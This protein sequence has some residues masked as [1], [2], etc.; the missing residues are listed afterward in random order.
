[1]APE[2]H[3]TLRHHH[4]G[5]I[6]LNEFMFK[7][8]IRIPFKFGIADLLQALF[9]SKLLQGYV[10]FAGKGN[11]KLIDNLLDSVPEWKLK[12]FCDWLVSPI[13]GG[14]ATRTFL[15]AGG[16]TGGPPAVSLD[17]PLGNQPSLVSFEGGLPLLVPELSVSRYSDGVGVFFIRNRDEKEEARLE[18]ALSI[19]GGGADEEG[20]CRPKNDNDFLPEDSSQGIPITAKKGHSVG[21]ISADSSLLTE[22]PARSL[23][24]EGTYK[25]PPPP[26]H[27]GPKD[28]FVVKNTWPPSLYKYR[29]ALNLITIRR[30]V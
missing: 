22:G 30:I 4:P 28:V 10:T 25:A 6:Y 24:L 18:E 27:N 3:E 5:C 9:I 29:L 2:P 13:G 12:F 15:Y 17:L 26:I 21:S 11:A 7:A 20:G 1:M 8:E 16:V 19:D 14:E 23:F